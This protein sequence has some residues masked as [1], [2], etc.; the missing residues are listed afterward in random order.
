MMLLLLLA[1]SKGFGPWRTRLLRRLLTWLSVLLARLLAV[2]GFRGM[3][4]L[5]A[6]LVNGDSGGACPLAPKV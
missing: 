4:T 3:M 1:A 6:E 5:D 2:E